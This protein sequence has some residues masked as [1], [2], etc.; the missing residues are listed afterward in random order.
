MGLP[1]QGSRQQGAFRG[2]V[3]QIGRG[4]GKGLNNRGIVILPPNPPGD[5]PYKLPENPFLRVNPSNPFSWLD[6]TTKFM[7]G[8]FGSMTNVENGLGDSIITGNGNPNDLIFK[9]FQIS[10][11][12]GKMYDLQKYITMWIKQNQE[13]NKDSIELTFPSKVA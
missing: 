11:L 13:A 12:L 10:A 7:T 2:F 3:P 4:G 6:G 1:I 5:D 8:L 9:K